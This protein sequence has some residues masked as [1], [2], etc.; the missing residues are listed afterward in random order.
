[1]SLER[2]QNYQF[3]K[4]FVFKFR[5]SLSCFNIRLVVRWLYSYV[6]NTHSMKVFQFIHFLSFKLEF[7]HS[8]MNFGHYCSLV[9]QMVTTSGPINGSNGLSGHLIKW[10]PLSRNFFIK[11]IQWFLERSKQFLASPNHFCWPPNKIF[12]FSKGCTTRCDHSMWPFGWW[13]NCNG[14][15]F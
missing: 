3:F 5:L 7:V 4:P 15:E 10:S 12:L 14:A 2:C 6:T 13:W 8:S 9:H 11:K 1:M